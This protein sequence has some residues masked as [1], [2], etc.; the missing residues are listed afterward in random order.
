MKSD[1]ELLEQYGNRFTD[2]PF[3]N[4]LQ[5]P[6]AIARKSTQAK[7]IWQLA[8]VLALA[9]IA[10]VL[11]GNIISLCLLEFKASRIESASDAI[12]QQHFPLETITDAK[13][14]MQQHLRKMEQAA[15]KNHF[16]ILL[17]T[18]GREITKSP[19]IRIERLDYR[20]GQI[21][22]AISANNFDRLD[23]LTAA[24]TQQGLQAKQQNSTIAGAE[25]KSTY[26]I[27][28]GGT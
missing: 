15:N 22:L 1:Q 4:L 3:I 18:L 20:N 24:L 28:A 16:L 10:V 25:V 14:Q 9:W 7:K 8:G 27:N 17:A 19:G 12:F 2:Y 21:T 13:Q 23:A 11:F 26:L 6:Y 5:K